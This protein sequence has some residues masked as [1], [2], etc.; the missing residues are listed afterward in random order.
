[1]SLS[2]KPSYLLM[3]LMATILLYSCKEGKI[4]PHYTPREAENLAREIRLSPIKPDTHVVGLFEEGNIVELVD[5]PGYRGGVDFLKYI[6][7]LLH[8]QGI[9]DLDLWFIAP[10]SHDRGNALIRGDSFDREI[11][12]LLVGEASY[13]HLYEEY[14][15]FL[16]YLYNLNRTIED[17]ESKINL[18]TL[19]ED[20][21]KRGIILVKE[22]RESPYPQVLIQ[23]PPLLEIMKTEEDRLIVS[24]IDQLSPL[25]EGGEHFFVISQG[26]PLLEDGQTLEYAMIILAKLGTVEKCHPVERGITKENF[27][28]AL[29]DFPEQKVTSPAFFAAS[30]MKGKQKKYLKNLPTI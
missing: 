29:K 27:N 13:L 16:E 1:M 30:L 10:Q 9:N 15:D 20:S 23:S 24:K 7:P 17:E 18:S 5:I 8:S 26:H 3:L 12:L 4:P 6:V 21:T 28:L 2:N 19:S 22:K 25:L 14:I 11:A